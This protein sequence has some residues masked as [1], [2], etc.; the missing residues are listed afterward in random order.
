MGALLN[1]ITGGAEAETFQP[2]NVNFGLFPPFDPAEVKRVKGRDRKKLY[3]DRAK[4][5][6][7]SWLDRNQGTESLASASKQSRIS[8]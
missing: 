4:P 2:M 6:F 7:L 3:T 8:A 5:E 1:H